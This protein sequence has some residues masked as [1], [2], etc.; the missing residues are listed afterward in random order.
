[1]KG[2]NEIVITIDDKFVGTFL[3]Q[4]LNNKYLDLGEEHANE[5]GIVLIGYLTASPEERADKER[6]GEVLKILSTV[7]KEYS[8]NFIGIFSILYEGLCSAVDEEKRISYGRGIA[9]MLYQFCEYIN[10]LSM[11]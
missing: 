5:A 9:I 4:M 1:M 11:R 10:G 6:A 2:R 3:N 8:K 7:F